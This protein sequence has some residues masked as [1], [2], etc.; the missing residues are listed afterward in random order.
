MFLRTSLVTWLCLFKTTSLSWFVS[1]VGRCYFYEFGSESQFDSVD[2]EPLIPISYRA[3]PWSSPWYISIRDWYIGTAFTVHYLSAFLLYLT[4]YLQKFIVFEALHVAPL[5]YMADNTDT[6]DAGSRLS[7]DY[8]T[9]SVPPGWRPHIR[10]YPFRRYQQLLKLWW[11]QTDQPEQQWGP[12]ICGRLK[13]PACQYAMSLQ[14]RRLDMDN[15]CWKTVT[16]PELFI[17]PLATL[18]TTCH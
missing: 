14:A 10:T 18:V 9:R 4:A 2:G 5:V 15:A 16:A 1:P 3:S 7:L 17:E 6:G 13:G 12:S 11:M 8:F